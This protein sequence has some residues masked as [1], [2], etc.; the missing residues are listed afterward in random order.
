MASNNQDDRT[1]TTNQSESHAQQQQGQTQL[2]A[3]FQ[4]QTHAQQAGQGQPQR[5]QQSGQQGARA[6]ETPN[7]ILTWKNETKQNEYAFRKI[8]TSDDELV[9]SGIKTFEA[10]ADAYGDE[11][12]FVTEHNISG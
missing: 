6:S 9:S 12:T 3:Q 7:E 4:D 5:Q 10:M 8:A 2:Q 1:V 11:T